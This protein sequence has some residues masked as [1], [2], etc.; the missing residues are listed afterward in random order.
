MINYPCRHLF[1]LESLFLWRLA[2]EDAAEQWVAV[3]EAAQAGVVVALAFVVE[4]VGVGLYAVAAV[5]EERRVAVAAVVG[6]QAERAIFK[7]VGDLPLGV[8]QCDGAAAQIVGIRRR[9]CS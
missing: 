4:A 1:L 2:V 9:I 8:A 5:V 3:D 6:K 7:A